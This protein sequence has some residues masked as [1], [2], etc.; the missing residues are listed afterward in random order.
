[1]NDLVPKLESSIEAAQTGGSFVPSWKLPH[2][3]DLV[4]VHAMLERVIRSQ[5]R[6]RGRWV[7]PMPVTP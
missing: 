5:R 1:M 7:L 3:H 4:D 6:I 2:E